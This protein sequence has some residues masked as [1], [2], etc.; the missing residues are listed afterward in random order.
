MK[1]SFLDKKNE[2]IYERYERRTEKDWNVCDKK[3]KLPAGE[4]FNSGVARIKNPERKASRS[5]REAGRLPLRT[6]PRLRKKYVINNV[7]THAI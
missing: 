4:V 6:S 5:L 1:S 2:I 7:N 3:T